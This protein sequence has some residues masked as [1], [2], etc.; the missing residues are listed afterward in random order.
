[1]CF[2]SKKSAYLRTFP[3]FPWKRSLISLPLKFRPMTVTHCKLT[4]IH[5][6]RQCSRYFCF[7]QIIRYF[8]VT[9]WKDYSFT[10]NFY[11]LITWTLLLKSLEPYMCGFISELNYT[12]MEYTYSESWYQK[13][14][15]PHFFVVVFY[16]IILSMINILHYWIAFKCLNFYKNFLGFWLD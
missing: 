8:S 9:E 14:L 7:F 4:C 5:C 11:P 13:R 1:M 10:L 16:R 6:V 12:E 2:L 3:L 15:C